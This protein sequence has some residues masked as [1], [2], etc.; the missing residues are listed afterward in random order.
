MIFLAKTSEEKGVISCS[1]YT[2][3]VDVTLTEA[4]WGR[5]AE[6]EKGE[7]RKESKQAFVQCGLTDPWKLP[8]RRVTN[9]D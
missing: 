3:T 6:L 2:H 7:T 5:I 9:D 1:F 8:G 4:G